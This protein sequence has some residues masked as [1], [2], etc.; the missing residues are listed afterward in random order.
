MKYKNSN[1]T[2]YTTDRS[3]FSMSRIVCDFSKESYILLQVRN[4]FVFI[5]LIHFNLETI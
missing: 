4:L 2:S 3:F 1:G 5:M